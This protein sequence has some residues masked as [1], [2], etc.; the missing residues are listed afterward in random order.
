MQA[1][2][3]YKVHTD[4]TKESTISIHSCWRAGRGDAVLD[5]SKANGPE[6]CDVFVFYQKNIQ[7]LCWNNILYVFLNLTNSEND[8]LNYVLRYY[9]SFFYLCI[10]I[11]VVQNLNNE[12][13]CHSNILG[14]NFSLF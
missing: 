10:F 13:H 1:Y 4:L 7:D 11:Y 8:V 6:V 9:H 12:F 5:G 14:S 2:K 3:V